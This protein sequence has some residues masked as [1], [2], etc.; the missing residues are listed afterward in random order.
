MC[1]TSW[2]KRDSLHEI[3]ISLLLYLFGICCDF[4][5]EDA[6]LS[7]LHVADLSYGECAMNTLQGFSP[8][9]CVVSVLNMQQ[10][11]CVSFNASENNLTMA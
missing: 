5:G 11:D 10:S 4:S 1:G 2:F 6:S 9:K 8:R 7:A 3:V